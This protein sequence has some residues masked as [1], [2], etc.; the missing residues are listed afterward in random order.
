MR[1]AEIPCNRRSLRV[2][3]GASTALVLTGFGVYQAESWG[4]RVDYTEVRRG[5]LGLSPACEFGD[6]F[7][8]KPECRN[9]DAPRLLIWGDSYA[10]HLVE[11]IAASTPLGLAQATKTTCG[12]VMGISVFR[13]GGFYNRQWA[14]GCLSFNQ[15]VLD[16]LAKTAS[17]QVVVLSSFLGQYLAGNRLITVDGSASDS[18]GDVKEREGG[19]AI[20]LAALRATITA[21]RGLGKRVVLVAPPPTADFDIG[22]CLELKANGKAVFGADNPSCAITEA[23]YRASRS[24]V[25]ALLDR[26][27]NEADVPVIRLDELLCHEELCAT[28]SNGIFIYRDGGHLSYDG[29]R[30]VGQQ[31]GLGE[32][33]I[34]IAR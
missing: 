6:R 27:A 31:L 10:M 34:A 12:P 5:N 23:H 8:P 20:A 7:D 2:A 18:P 22:R 24:A 9:S 17:V 29:S 26:V 25:L 19:E 21:I 13:P 28:E 4:G 11:G 32:R 1:Q 3:L 33:L 15:S 16:Y 14:E 30:L